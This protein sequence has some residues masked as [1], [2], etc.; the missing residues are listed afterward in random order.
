MSSGSS[1]TSGSSG[2][3]KADW[4]ALGELKVSKSD[5]RAFNGVF[6]TLMEEHGELTAL[7]LRINSSSDVSVY[8]DLYP[9]VRR[10]LLAHEMGEMAAV[11]PFVAAY[12][13]LESEAVRHGKEA[14]ELKGA[15]MSI[16]V[17][18]YGDARWKLGFEHVFALVRSHF[19]EEETRFFPRAQLLI[20][21][22]NSEM[23][24]ARYQ[25]GKVVID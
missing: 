14:G 11:Y 20:G 17:L 23:L 16:D 10:E 8:K 2:F 7:F 21:Q 1:G 5:L 13:D 6:Q 4:N 25:E 3:G 19:D 12:A 9:A 18:D 24:E 22:E 15:I